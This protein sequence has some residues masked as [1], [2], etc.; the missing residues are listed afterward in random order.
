MS[1]C[2]KNARPAW[3]RA[4]ARHPAGLTAAMGIP[5]A[6]RTGAPHA[7]KPSAQQQGGTTRMT[8]QALGY[9]GV[10]TATPDDWS[11]FAT[12]MVGMQAVER[13]AAGRAFRMDDRKQRLIIDPALADGERYFGW[14]VADAAALDALAA[15]LEAAG[16]RGEAGARGAR[17]PAFRQRA[18]LV[19]RPGRAPVGGV[20]RRAGRRHNVQPGPQRLR[21]PHRAPR[22][23]AHGADRSA[24][25]GRAAVLPRRAGLQG[26]RLRHRRGPGVFP[27][28]QP[29]PSQRGA[30]S[31]A[32]G[33]ACT[34]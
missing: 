19:H 27:A 1:A 2:K 29:A 3:E 5:R 30:C 20:P 16:T 33:A 28:R 8:I 11:D 34:T 32:A 7:G 21:L 6:G 26:Q 15:R 18:D 22:H 9:V 31:R 17:R 10:G 4:S 23:G 25:G 12:G 13:G 24:H 14:E